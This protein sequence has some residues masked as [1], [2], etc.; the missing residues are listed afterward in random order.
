[1]NNIH[2]DQNL[3]KAEQEALQVALNDVA[4]ERYCNNPLLP[5]YKS[6]AC[7]YRKLLR[8]TR[9][10]FHISDC[11]G[12]VLQQHRDEIQ[13]LLD[14]ADQG[15]LT[16][17]RDFKVNQ[18]VSGECVRIFG[19]KIAGI[20]V[21]ELLE[22][23]QN[24]CSVRMDDKLQQV[25]SLPEEETKSLLKQLS[26]VVKIG[27][28]DIKVEYKRIPP[29]D[30]AAESSLIMMILTDMTEKMKAEARI[31]Y[32]SFHD[33]LTNLYNRA[34]V[35]KIV[36]DHEELSLPWSM[37]MIDL[38]GLKLINDVFGHEQGDQLLIA[39]ANVLTESCRETDVVSRWGGDEFLILLPNTDYNECLS[40]CER[41]RLSCA[42]KKIRSIPLL[43]AAIGMVTETEGRNYFS[44]LFNVAEHRM[45]HDKLVESR[46]VKKDIIVHMKEMLHD[47]CFESAGHSERIRFLTAD[48]SD[49]LGISLATPDMKQLDQLAVLHD[50]GKVAIP[51]E[52][53]G[54]TGPLTPV[55]WEIMKSHSD[56][57]YRMAQSIGELALA[58][59]ILSLH[60]RWDG[61]GY[62]CRLKGEEISFLARMFSIV[63]VYDVMTHDRPYHVA[64]NKE[65]ALKELVRGCGSQFDPMLTQR[66]IEFIKN[67]PEP[68][69]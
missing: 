62:P 32:L 57:G 38:N 10:I 17:G 59:I 9:K 8:V 4:D 40:V 35:E 33:K 47:R 46:K 16:F 60:E 26:S 54:K 3:F 50:I 31:H 24:G 64:L 67:R 43:S 14:N 37:M 22:Y 69:V 23:C 63:D 7:N 42:E 49:Y 13:N 15:F 5:R 6:L 41:I 61:N 21:R 27:N 65:Q 66:F 34:Y 28:K 68:S 19:R 11:Q 39:M 53:L 2:I 55:D 48:F 56:I 36:Q 58:D 29:P 44:E 12:Q 18:Q 52:I 1:M 25:F 45:Y 30:N 51:A 20:S